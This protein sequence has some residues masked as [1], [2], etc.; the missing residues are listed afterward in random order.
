MAMTHSKPA[1]KATRLYHK[2]YL[3]LIRNSVGSQMFRNFY[4]QMPDGK[5]IDVMGDGNT[6]CAFFVTSVLVL[7]GKLARIHGTVQVT[8]NDLKEKAWQEVAAADMQP[9]D[10]IVWEAQ[11]LDKE[12][13]AH[14]GFY[15]GNGR[16]VSTSAQKREVAEHDVQFDGNRAI[17][18]VL[19]EPVGV[20]V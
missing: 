7:F 2:T 18:T 9:G 11:E 8:V 19:R 14:I 3:Q 12:W 13:H 1:P 4:L 6:S 16:A 15:I 5:E 10:V 20:E 17:T